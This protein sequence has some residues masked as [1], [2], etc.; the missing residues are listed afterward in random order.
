MHH[1]IIL[2][3]SMGLPVHLI[4][5]DAGYR[6][7]PLYP[8][9]IERGV[10]IHEAN[11]FDAIIPGAPVLS[12]CNE[13]FLARIDEI[14]FYSH[15]TV[16][17]NC[18]T[19]LF[20][21]EKTRHRQG[22]IGTFLYQNEEVMLKN[23]A[24]LR[25]INPDPDIRHLLVSPYFADSAFPFVDRTCGDSETQNDTFV[26]GRISRQDADK[27]SA[28][29]LWVWEGI[30][31]PVTKQGVMLGFGP[32]SENKIGRPQE[33]ISTYSNQTELSQQ[34]F[35]RRVD[36]I[37]QPMD[38]TENWPRIGLEAMASGSVLIVDNRGGWREM[39]RH[40]VTGWLCD[41]PEDFVKYATL[42]SHQPDQRRAMARA[43]RQRLAELSAEA[44]SKKSWTG[45][46]DSLQNRRFDL[47]GP[48]KTPRHPIEGI[49]EDALP[50]ISCV[51]PT[52]GRPAYVNEA[53]QMFL[54]QDYP[55]KELIILND[56]P[57]QTYTS[58]LPPEAG[59]RV[60]NCPERYATL[61]EK[62]NACIEHTKGSII[63]VWDDDDVYLPWR[64]S[65][66]LEQMRQHETLFYRPAE[67]WAW[68]G[69]SQAL[70]HNQAVR[71]WMHHSMVMFEKQV[72]RR[73]NGY[74][75]MD[76]CEDT[77]FSDR[78]HAELG[79]DFLRYRIDEA[80]R[81]FILRGKSR[82]AHMSMPGGDSPLD[83]SPRGTII[84]QPYA[85]QD[86]GLLDKKNQL[87]AFRNARQKQTNA[88][89]K[90]SCLMVTQPGRLDMALTAASQFQQ[91]TW[92]NREL[93]L[94]CDGDRHYFEQLKHRIQQVADNATCIF[95]EGHRSLGELR[96]ISVG[97]ATGDLVCQWDDDD[98]YHPRR[99]EIQANHLLGNQ[100][101]FCYLTDQLHFFADTRELCWVDWT[102]D[103]AG[104]LHE[105]TPT[106]IAIPGTLMARRDQM[107][108]YQRV[109]LGEDSFLIDAVARSKKI[110]MLSGMGWCHMYIF[111]GM[112]SF[113][114][115]HHAAIVGSWYRLLTHQ[116]VSINVLDQKTQRPAED[117]SAFTDALKHYTLDD[118]GTIYFRTP[119]GKQPVL[120]S[121]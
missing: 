15:N 100:L 16:F 43:A 105:H 17:V 93:V 104:H 19:W 61:G 12:F 8:E 38:T 87:V 48:D 86:T 111:H 27:F 97:A 77:D 69:D 60:I 54:D 72:W 25:E 9:M 121:V 71:D 44:V 59:V 85:I 92:A 21:R 62:R 79:Q 107:T 110:G 20:E 51:M 53:V 46:I 11:Q 90:V 66:S 24:L 4:P 31:S 14:L 18:M 39:I 2:W 47:V 102:R 81:F 57:G 7:E 114:R 117:K 32:D 45:V 75:A 42:M 106:R 73:V 65:Y 6:N 58:E 99:L 101:D 1:Q 119:S 36:V 37:V 55:R 63:A 41:T 49:D 88:K 28:D 115:A 98:Q 78:V 118:P 29:T 80:D 10:V 22:K 103:A 64:L 82:Y 3:R 91:Q 83:I 113:N 74:A 67:Y 120:T 76:W 33:W 56:C 95:V 109:A 23:A 96:N 30:E 84:I 70:H 108:D 68:W 50:L 52:Y 40:G 116:E 5:C 35:Y 94:V 112:N 34:D 89:P 26:I 13:S